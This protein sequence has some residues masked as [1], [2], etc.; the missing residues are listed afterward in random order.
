ML[1]PLQGT[2]SSGRFLRLTASASDVIVDMNVGGRI[3]DEN[4]DCYY[5]KR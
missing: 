1:H 5:F 3:D 4:L 2:F